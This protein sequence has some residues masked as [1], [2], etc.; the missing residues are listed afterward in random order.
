MMLWYAEGGSG[1]RLL[2]ACVCRKD[3][4]QQL[5]E[6][7]ALP[8]T[9]QAACGKEVALDAH[10]PLMVQERLAALLEER[11]KMGEVIPEQSGSRPTTKGG[12]KV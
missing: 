9:L 12:H 6:V 4:G 7:L 5:R 3:L 8:G 1:R 10:C 11:K 2:H